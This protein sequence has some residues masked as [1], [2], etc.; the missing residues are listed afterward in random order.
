MGIP[1]REEELRDAD[2]WSYWISRLAGLEPFEGVITKNFVP[3]KDMDAPISDCVRRGDGRTSVREQRE[4]LF[5][6]P[7]AVIWIHAI[8]GIAGPKAFWKSGKC[9]FKRAVSLCS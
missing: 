6:R 4:V 2:E 7:E 3:E 1:F 9:H 8:T 5:T